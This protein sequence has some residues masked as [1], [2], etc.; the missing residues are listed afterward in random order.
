MNSMSLGGLYFIYLSFLS[1]MH[2]ILL[3]V[4]FAVVAAAVTQA[5]DFEFDMR[6]PF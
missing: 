2:E 4:I 5:N 1:M 6:S 3:A